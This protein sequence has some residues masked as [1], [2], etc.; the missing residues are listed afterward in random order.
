MKRLQDHRTYEYF[1]L[2]DIL[3]K[4]ELALLNNSYYVES[5]YVIYDKESIAIK[6][7]YK[8]YFIN[9][10]TIWLHDFKD[11]LQILPTLI[12]TCKED[13]K[14][15]KSALKMIDT[16]NFNIRTYTLKLKDMFT[17]DNLKELIDIYLYLKG[18]DCYKFKIKETNNAYKLTI[19]KK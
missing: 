7:N 14:K 17:E 11:Q 1:K 4:T 3:N 18:V 5:C 9:L 19:I 16:I 13:Y 12:G 2:K 15:V 6:Y 10:S 8:G